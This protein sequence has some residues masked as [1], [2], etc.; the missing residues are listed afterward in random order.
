MAATMLYYVQKLKWK[1]EYP[2]D[3][4]SDNLLQL[5]TVWAAKAFPLFSRCQKHPG[6]PGTSLP[7]QPAFVPKSCHPSVP[8]FPLRPFMPA[9]KRVCVCVCIR[10]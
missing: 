3:P 2:T 6:R 4:S 9:A 1:L 10:T 5:S 8:P 7:P